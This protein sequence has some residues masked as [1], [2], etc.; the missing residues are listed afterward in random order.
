MK[1][2]YTTYRDIIYEDVL[3]RVFQ[4]GKVGV[5]L[6]LAIRKTLLFKLR[7]QV[8]ESI[9]HKVYLYETQTT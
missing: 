2:R 5:P 9:R 7:T 3:E 4:G 8:W 6:S 1:L